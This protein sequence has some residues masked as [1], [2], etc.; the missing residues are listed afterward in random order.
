MVHCGFEATAVHEAFD[1][2]WTM[3]PISLFG[4]KTKGPTTPDIALDG[5]RPAE[6]VFTRNIEHRLA[7]IGKPE[8]PGEHLSAAE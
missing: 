2:P 5:Q 7:E 4:I 1:R 8:A 6:Y 3:L